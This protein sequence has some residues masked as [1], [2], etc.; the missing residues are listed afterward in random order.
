MYLYSNITRVFN[1]DDVL[2]RLVMLWVTI[3][4]LIIVGIMNIT[5]SCWAL[6][7][8]KDVHD[9]FELSNELFHASPTVPSEY[10][11]PEIKIESQPNND[12]PERNNEN[13]SS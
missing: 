7:H 12:D 1:I 9:Y 5:C 8:Y 6:H 13:V 4:V 11:P 2:N 10:V 3:V